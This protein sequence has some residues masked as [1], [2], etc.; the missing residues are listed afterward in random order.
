MN[1]RSNSN[2]IWAFF[3]GSLLGAV[4]ALLFAPRSGRET[5]QFLVDESQK[6]KDTAIESIKDVRSSAESALKDAQTRLGLLA[7]ETK[8]YVDR[9]KNVES[10]RTGSV[11]APAK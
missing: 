2:A 7:Q 11:P 1:D 8:D 4:I 9:L 10:E 3:A 5:R 6:I